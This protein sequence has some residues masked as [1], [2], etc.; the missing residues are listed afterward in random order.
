MEKTDRNGHEIDKL[1]QR[2]LTRGQVPADG[3]VQEVKNMNEMLKKGAQDIQNLQ[4][5]TA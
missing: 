1:N 2:E 5:Q 3:V 4:Q